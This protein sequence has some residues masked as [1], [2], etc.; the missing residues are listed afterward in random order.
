MGLIAGG[1]VY[2]FAFEAASGQT[3]G[4]RRYGIGAGGGRADARAI[5]IRSVLRIVD[6]LPLWYLSGLISMLRTGP[7]RRQRI[8]DVVAGTSVVA[9]SGRALSRGTPGW[10]LPAAAIAAFLVCIASW[11]FALTADSR[12]MTAS[13]S[14]AVVAGCQRGASGAAIDCQCLLDRLQ[15][16]GYDTIS[17]LQSLT[18]AVRSETEEGAF[19]R[20]RRELRA[21]ALDCQG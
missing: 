3:P 11:Y 8:G 1:I 14:A 16:D 6:Q 4:K 12:P 17:S 5:A 18:S 19:G 9:I 7:R 10:L 20:A 13:Q 2:H 21:A 15:A